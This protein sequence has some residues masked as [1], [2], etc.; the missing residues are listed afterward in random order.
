MQESN[1]KSKTETKPT[2]PKRSVLKNIG[3]ILKSFWKRHKIIS[4]III[5]IV[6]GYSYSSIS[7][8][9]G[10]ITAKKVVTFKEPSLNGMA[11]SKACDAVRKDGWKDITVD[12]DYDD[13]GVRTGDCSDSTH[14][15]SDAYYTQADSDGTGSSVEISYTLKESELTDDEKAQVKQDEAGSNDS[16]SN[17]S[18]NASSSS[19]SNS[20]QSNHS[21]SSKTVNDGSSAANAIPITSSDASKITGSNFVKKYKGKYIAFDGL[22]VATLDS[23]NS[24]IIEGSSWDIELLIGDDA[25]NNQFDPTSNDASQLMINV[26]D[27]SKASGV[28]ASNLV[29]YSQPSSDDWLENVNNVVKIHAVAKVSSYGGNGDSTGYIFLTPGSYDNTAITS[30]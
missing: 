11:V 5:I 27:T 18:S 4:I 23:S 7:G 6:F 10:S 24:P 16:S 1:D 30:R 13:Y 14:K 20:N 9:I 21:A 8:W 19:S 25:N 15:V 17:S 28:F 29:Q 2:K 3:I 26:Q 22:Y 12:G